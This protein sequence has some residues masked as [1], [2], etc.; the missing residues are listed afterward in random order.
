VT[1]G[2]EKQADCLSKNASCKIKQK[3]FCEFRLARAESTGSGKRSTDAE[4]KMLR[5]SP[6][7]HIIY[8]LRSYTEC[9]VDV[10]I[11]QDP[12]SL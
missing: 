5:I 6:L 9:P 10:Y 7:C 12:C 3:H 2:E 11:R 4:R 8:I 1:P